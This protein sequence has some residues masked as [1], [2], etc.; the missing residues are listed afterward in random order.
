MFLADYWPELLRDLNDY[1]SLRTQLSAVE[2]E[3]DRMRE[4]L[5][6]ISDGVR[7]FLADKSRLGHNSANVAVVQAESVAEICADF[8]D[9]ALASES[10]AT[11]HIQESVT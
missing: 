6:K 7:K 4:A 11:A 9:A 8:A 5:T 3:R 10:S 2:A 1:D